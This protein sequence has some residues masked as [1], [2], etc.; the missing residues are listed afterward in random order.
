MTPHEILADL[1]AVGISVR[2]SDDRA[3]LVVPAGRLTSTRREVV[4]ENKQA[5]VDF[6]NAARSTTEA[7]IAAAMRVCDQHHDG[8]S[9]RQEM[10]T[11]CLE[12]PPHLH[13]DLLDHFQQTA[14]K[15]DGR[16][17]HE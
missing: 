9:A 3:N 11:Q 4:L 14:P 1:W 10:Q 12:V 7:M 15:V 13:T 2:L 6:L 8:E 17:D 16:I 5:I